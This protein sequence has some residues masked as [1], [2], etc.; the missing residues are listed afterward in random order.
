[1]TYKIADFPDSLATPNGSILVTA[2]YGYVNCRKRKRSEL[3]VALDNEGVNLYDV[4][5]TLPD[6]RLLADFIC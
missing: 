5:L 2:V 4:Y 3:A 1:M 6:I